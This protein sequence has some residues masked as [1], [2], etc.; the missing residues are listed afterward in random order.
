[1]TLGGTCM[2]SSFY[3][4]ANPC[5]RDLPPWASRC[6]V[7]SVHHLN[8]RPDIICVCSTTDRAAKRSPKSPVISQEHGVRAMACW[9]ATGLGLLAPLAV[10]KIICLKM[11]MCRFL[12]MKVCESWKQGTA[13]RSDL[14]LDRDPHQVLIR[15]YCSP[16]FSCQQ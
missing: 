6:T 13:K 3:Y 1:M 15:N 16:E 12:N 14:S 5:P 8:D 9:L 2:D 4:I 11:H 10:V 7:I